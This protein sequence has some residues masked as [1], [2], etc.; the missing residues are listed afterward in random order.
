MNAHVAGVIAHGTVTDATG[1]Q[2]PSIISLNVI[3]VVTG[4]GA[5]G[6][7]PLVGY[8]VI[9]VKHH[10]KCRLACAF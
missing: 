4:M 8:I 3:L 2:R 7:A 10:K 1:Q 6:I 5:T 9:V